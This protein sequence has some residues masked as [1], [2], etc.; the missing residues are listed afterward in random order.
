[1]AVSGVNGMAVAA[2]AG[3]ALLIWSGIKGASVSSSLKD[4]ISGHQ[5]SGNAANPVSLASFGDSGSGSSGSPGASAPNPGSVK[6]N[7]AMGKMMAAAHGWTGQQWNDLYALWQRESGWNNTA[8]NPSSGAYGIPQA[9]P[10]TKMPLAAQKPGGSHAS[11]QI[12]WGLS[13][14]AQRYG[15]PSAAWAHETSAGWY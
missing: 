9:L 1:M 14:I 3:G 15:N 11:A 5:P 13:Y 8:E 6:G 4:L 2:T 12:S 7:V 10:P